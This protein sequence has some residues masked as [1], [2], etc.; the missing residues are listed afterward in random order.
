MKNKYKYRV[1]VMQYTGERYIPEQKITMMGLEHLHRYFFA[2]KYAENKIL[3]DIACGEGYGS[4]ILSQTASKVYGGDISSEVIAHA[5][6]KYPDICF[7]QQNITKL[8]FSDNMFDVITCFETIEHLALN[9]QPAALAELSRVLKPEGMLL[10]STPLPESDFHV[11]NKFHPGELSS[12]NF[13]KLLKQYFPHTEIYGQSL[14][15]SS[16]IGKRHTAEIINPA[17]YKKNRYLIAVCSSVP[18]DTASSSVFTDEESSVM[19][20]ICRLKRLLAPLIPLQNFL[21]AALGLLMP[22]QKL[23]QKISRYRW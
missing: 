12:E 1:E 20:Q 13:E 18:F 9:D 22:T 10:I 17:E 3:L 19:L 4:Q 6:R 21:I 16:I 23:K 7:S 5:Q 8:D 11:P 14:C 15:Y 2:K